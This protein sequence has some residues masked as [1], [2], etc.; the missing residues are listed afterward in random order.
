MSRSVDGGRYQQDFDQLPV[1]TS[2]L[3]V[4]VIDMTGL[5]LPGFAFGQ[6]RQLWDVPENPFSRS[7]L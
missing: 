2:K 3:A 5:L 6:S 4:R 1:Y 7:I